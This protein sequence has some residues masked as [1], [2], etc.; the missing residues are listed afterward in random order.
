MA[1]GHH[2]QGS[3]RGRPGIWCRVPLARRSCATLARA[4][5]P[6]CSHASGL[7]CSHCPHAALAPFC[8][9]AVILAC[10][11]GAPL[12]RRSRASLELV[13]RRFGAFRAPL[14]CLFARRSGVARAPLAAGRTHSII[15]HSKRVETVALEAAAQAIL[16][17][18]AARA[19]RRRSRRSSRALEVAPPAAH[20]RQNTIESRCHRACEHGGANRTS[21]R[22]GGQSWAATTGPA[23]VGAQ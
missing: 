11:S 19:W 15:V 21:R 22:V 1:E 9:R 16:R 3:P 6:L 20:V 10:R 2:L 4:L 23:V 7:A 17:A 5:A 12:A 8:P 13:A 18:M 14:S